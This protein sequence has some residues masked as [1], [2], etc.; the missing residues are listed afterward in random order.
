MNDQTE[1]KKK[2]PSYV[3]FQVEQKEGQEKP[4][5]TQV[6]ATWDNNDGKGFNLRF[7]LNGET[8]NLVARK[9]IP[10]SE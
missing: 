8:I 2:L 7:E 6:G 1:T 5:W 4:D 10:R 9:F 3:L